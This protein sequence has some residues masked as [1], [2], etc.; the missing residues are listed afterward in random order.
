[1]TN[2]YRIYNIHLVNGR[3]LSTP[4][5]PVLVDKNYT[6]LA[7][8]I[9]PVAVEQGE[10]NQR[11]LNLRINQQNVLFIDETVAKNE[12]EAMDLDQMFTIDVLDH[13]SL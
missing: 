10:T 9:V 3:V 12:K 13:P 8:F 5:C 4:V 2:T 7:Y 6:P 11:F 1:M